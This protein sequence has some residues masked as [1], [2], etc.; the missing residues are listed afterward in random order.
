MSRTPFRILNGYPPLEHRHGIHHGMVGSRSGQR[1]PSRICAGEPGRPCQEKCGLRNRTRADRPQEKGWGHA[2]PEGSHDF[3]AMP[4]FANGTACDDTPRPA[5]A[6]L[7][8]IQIRML[9]TDV[10]KDAGRVPT[11]NRK[12]SGCRYLRRSLVRK[13]QPLISC[14]GLDLSI[15]GRCT[16][17]TGS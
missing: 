10:V 3:P 6:D 7:V 15:V 17:R 14:R 9:R 11:L 8:E 13:L 12:I 2:R 16:M 1:L 4:G 5:E